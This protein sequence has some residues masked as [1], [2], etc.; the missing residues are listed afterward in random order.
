MPNLA[1]VLFGTERSVRRFEARP[2]TMLPS[3]AAVSACIASRRP[4]TRSLGKQDVQQGA[5]V[6]VT[7]C[8]KGDRQARADRV[9]VASSH[10]LSIQVSRLDQVGDDPLCR[11]LGD[12]HV[13]GDVLHPSLRVLGDRE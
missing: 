10:P 11:T 5:E 2:V 7:A 8:Q 12:A 3:P 1:Q 4:P 9:A 13:C 6:D